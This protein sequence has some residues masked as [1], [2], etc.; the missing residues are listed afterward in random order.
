MPRGLKLGCARHCVLCADASHAAERSSG[1]MLC[2]VPS[3]AAVDGAERSRSQAF[4]RLLENQFCFSPSSKR[5]SHKNKRNGGMVHYTGTLTIE[6][7]LL[8]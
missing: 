8:S 7:I 2:A 1:N 3:G 5:S 4:S 6:L